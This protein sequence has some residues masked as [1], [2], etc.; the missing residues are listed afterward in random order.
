MTRC[1]RSCVT[2]CK[3]WRCSTARSRHSSIRPE[4]V[5]ASK[6]SRDRSRARRIATVVSCPTP[7]NSTTSAMSASSTT[8]AP[9]RRGVTRRR[10]RR[11]KP[12]TP[13]ASGCA[14]ARSRVK[15]IHLSSCRRT[16]TNAARRAPWS[17]RLQ[18]GLSR[19]W[20]SA[21]RG[22]RFDLRR[23]LRGSLHTGGEAVVPR[24]RARVRRRAAI[25]GHRR[26]QP[27]DGRRRPS[28]RCA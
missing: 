27:L 25:R 16:P 5:Q 22:R 18:R 13:R 24:W 23:T 8:T 10:T 20:H 1:G 3:T 6:A 2:R 28:R 12:R 21:P 9:S 17:N 26:W 4:R 19:R 7:K 14:T 15:A 11:A